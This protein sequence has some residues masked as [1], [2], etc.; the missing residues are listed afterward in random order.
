MPFDI[1][2]PLLFSRASF[3]MKGRGPHSSSFPIPHWNIL[4]NECN[5]PCSFAAM[6]RAFP[7]LS[8]QSGFNQILLHYGMSASC[9][10]FLL[11][12][13]SDPQ[14]IPSPS[15]KHPDYDLIDGP[16]VLRLASPDDAWILRLLRR[17]R[18]SFSLS[19]PWTPCCWRWFCKL[20]FF[21]D[22]L[23]I[24]S[25]QLKPTRGFFPFWSNVHPTPL[26]HY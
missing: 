2:L 15:L 3:K 4:E 23:F 19:L 10:S 5:L 9:S 25:R 8:S 16:P 26:G 11:T 13:L 7:F 6:P 24:P 12:N 20:S 18:D 21:R 22:L 14:A 17:R 1:S